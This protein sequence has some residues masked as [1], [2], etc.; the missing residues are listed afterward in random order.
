[1]SKTTA[2]TVDSKG[3]VT[4]PAEAREALGMTPGTVLFVDREGD[5]LRLAKA[6]NP[7]DALAAH[8]LAEY[9][10]GQ[11]MSLREFARAEGISLDG[12]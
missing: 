5:V 2:I 9:R 1:M 7:F 3:R 4:L 6:V 12:A 10:S 11:T 8:A